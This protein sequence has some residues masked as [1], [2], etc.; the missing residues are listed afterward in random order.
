MD[1][2]VEG[3]PLDPEL[4]TD[5]TTPFGMLS[6]TSRLQVVWLLAAG[7]S[8]VG[9]LAGTLGQPVAAAGQH[10]AELKP[11]G[12]VRSRREGRHQIYAIADPRAVELVQ[13]VVG[14]EADRRRAGRSGRAQG[15]A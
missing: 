6:A 10:L 12:P 9:T 3:H 4:L 8:D 5:V 14:A 7:P 15:I 11:A 2:P 13:A 1:E